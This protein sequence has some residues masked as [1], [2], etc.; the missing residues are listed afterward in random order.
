MASVRETIKRRRSLVT[1]QIEELG[2]AEKPT[3][4]NA[5]FQKTF[6]EEDEEKP[7]A[8][9][10]K[11]KRRSLLTRILSLLTGGAGGAVGGGRPGNPGHE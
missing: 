11:P 3:T 6:F 9:K 10:K 1:R 2:M 5:R 8:S 4:R 7:E